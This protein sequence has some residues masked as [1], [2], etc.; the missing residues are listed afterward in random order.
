MRPGRFYLGSAFVL[1]AALF[2]LAGCALP[3]LIADRDPSGQGGHGGADGGATQ[4]ITLASGEAKPSAIAVDGGFAYWI[5]ELDDTVMKLSIAEGGVPVV[6]IKD[7]PSPC[8]LAAAFNFVI[9]KSRSMPA[10]LVTY[11]QAGEQLAVVS[12]DSGTKCSI[13]IDPTTANVYWTTINSIVWSP[14][15]ANAPTSFHLQTNPITINAADPAAIYWTDAPLEPAAA[16]IYTLAKGAPVQATLFVKN[17]PAPCGIT[18]S[19]G[20]VFWTTNTT[21][22]SIMKRSNGVDTLIASQEQGPCAIAVDAGRVYWANTLG[23]Q[24]RSADRFGGGPITIA[25]GQ[26]TPCSI[27]VD[28]ERVYWT[29]CDGGTVMAAYKPDP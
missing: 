29:T 12:T 20:E 24:V 14:L 23:G 7:V 27:A 21:P 9:V 19:N 28:N 22:G 16:G 2:P 15:S 18:T 26:K 5:N 3:E 25:E 10:P 4:L 13:S 6:L 17:N 1:C 8:A 11:T